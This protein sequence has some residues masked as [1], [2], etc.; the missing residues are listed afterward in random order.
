MSNN[1]EILRTKA[2]LLTASI[3]AMCNAKDIDSVAASFSEA[4]NL[5]VEIFKLN[6]EKFNN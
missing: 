5:L 6:V 2:A 4:K 1:N 3:N